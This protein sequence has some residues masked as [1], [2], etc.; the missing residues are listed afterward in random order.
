MYRVMFKSVRVVAISTAVQSKWFFFYQAEDG[1]RD[2][3]VTGVQTCALT[4]YRRRSMAAV[5][6]LMAVYLVYAWPPRPPL[7][8]GSSLFASYWPGIRGRA[9]IFR[10]AIQIG[11]ASCWERL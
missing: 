2:L 11:R 8:Y 1:I 4:I 5:N 6:A 3:T 9:A 10:G 7:R